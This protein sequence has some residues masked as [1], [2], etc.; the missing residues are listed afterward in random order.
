[1]TI[2]YV[3][4]ISNLIEELREDEKALEAYFEKLGEM[5]IEHILKHNKAEDR[6]RTL[7]ASLLLLFALQKEGYEIES[8]PDFAFTGKGKPYIPGLEQLHFNLSHSKNIITCV[9]SNEE[10]GVDIEHIRDMK[11]ATIN[12]V[13]SEKEKRMAGYDMEGY[14]RLWTMKEACAKLIGTGLSEI[15]DGLEISEK[16]DD[17]IVEKLNRDTTKA[18]CYTVTAEGKISDSLEYPYYYSVC[19]HTKEYVKCIYTKWDNKNILYC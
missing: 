2:L 19:S 17:T 10:V 6:A 16:G 14:V 3:C 9:I 7:G 8:L 1:M 11:D 4:E 12:K 13:F 18:F 15:L 5:R